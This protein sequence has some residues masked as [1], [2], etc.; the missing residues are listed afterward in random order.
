MGECILN[1]IFGYII[2]LIL[3]GLGVGGLFYLSHPKDYSNSV[4]ED[5][6]PET[7]FNWDNIEEGMYVKLDVN[8]QVAYYSYK[9]DENGKDITRLYLV[10]DYNQ[11]TNRY[12]HLIGVMVNSD[13]FDDWDSLEKGELTQKKLLKKIT[14]TNYVH[15]IPSTVLKSLSASL[16]FDRDDANEIEK[17]IVPYYIGDEAMTEGLAVYKIV[18]WAAIGLGGILLIVSVIGSFM[19][20]D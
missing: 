4:L 17:M 20:K 6:S 7:G 15:K 13:E 19:N 5:I 14:V 2:A 18:A 3:I 1:K 11:K 10:F 12:S 9:K 16:L 8:N